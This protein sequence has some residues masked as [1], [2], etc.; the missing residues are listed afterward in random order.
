MKFQFSNFFKIS[1]VFSALTAVLFIYSCKRENVP[2]VTDTNV[3]SAN[4]PVDLKDELKRAD[5]AGIM[6]YNHF[7]Y[8]LLNKKYDN[9]FWQ[10]EDQK[11]LIDAEVQNFAVLTKDLNVEQRFDKLVEQKRLTSN[12]SDYLKQFLHGLEANSSDTTISWNFATSEQKKIISVTTFSNEEK[13]TLL[14]FTSLAKYYAKELIENEA[15]NSNS[16]TKNKTQ[17][18]DIC[19]ANHEIFCSIGNGL[20]QA[21]ISAGGDAIGGFA[22]AVIANFVQSL[23]GLPFGSCACNITTVCGGN[24]QYNLY[25]NGA[26]SLTQGIFVGGAQDVGL[27]YASINTPNVYPLT[28]DMPQGYAE[29]TQL[30]S[31]NFGVS[32]FTKCTD[33][34]QGHVQFIGNFYSLIHSP[35]SPG[36]IQGNGTPQ[37]GSIENYYVI[38]NVNQPG[39][40]IVATVNG[41]IGQVLGSVVGQAGFSVQVRW[42]RSG[43]GS[44]DIQTKSPCLELS[45]KVTIQI[46]VQ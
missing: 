25:F 18:R 8:N 2:A 22:G 4:A 44:L 40:S 15:E 12:E 17:F 5:A 43:W 37:S 21:T 35:G 36:Y 24:A 27:G 3:T 16:L 32:A 41:S 10:P 23:I 11:K 42:F 7:K 6:V 39:S 26:C 46:K 29:I 20:I 9:Y 30:N 14:L 33:P 28:C 45:N 34:A 38:G 13:S 1:I 31:S 19:V